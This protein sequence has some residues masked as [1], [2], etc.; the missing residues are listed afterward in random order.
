M[1]KHIPNI[2]SISRIPLAIS[3]PFL[4]LLESPWPFL[5]VFGLCG[6]TDVLD[7]ILARALKLQSKLGEKLDSA[8]DGIAIVCYITAVILGVDV[9]ITTLHWALFGLLMIGR[10]HNMVFTWSKF[11]RVGFIHLRS[12]RWA[13]VAIWCLM[14]VSVLLGYLPDIP[15]AILLGAV[16]LSGFEETVI[17]AKMELNEY[18]MTL[19]S[20]WQ[21]Q[22]DR[23]QIAANM[24]PERDEVLV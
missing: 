2:L 6:V 4:V 24:Q 14:P 1:V 5:V 19:K 7:G 15:L 21:W 3:L 20:Y 18:T 22:R 11:R 8:A 9:V 23:K 13:A 17:L 10:A 16:T 12:M